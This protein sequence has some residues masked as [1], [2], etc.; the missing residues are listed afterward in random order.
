MLTRILIVDDHA[1]V[2][3][4]IIMFLDTE[5]SIQVVGEA[6]DG[7]DAIQKASLLKPDVIL[8]DLV[9]PNRDGVNTI[10]ELKSCCPSTKIII[11]TSF[12]DEKNVT[13]AIKAGADGYLLKDADGEALLRAIQMVQ[14][15]GMPLHPAVTNYL[16]KSLIQSKSA[17]NQN[18]LTGREKEILLLVAKGL[19]NQG[20]AE[21]LAISKGTV[22]VHMSNIL[23]KLNASSR[24][25]AVFSAAQRGLISPGASR[26]QP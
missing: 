15:G 19:S 7:Q 18:Q 5:P 2:R 11:L 12:D 1:V 8:L 4:G 21:T 26:E 13:A 17:E 16:L 3:K 14:T 10:A 22:K 25:E 20:V 9:M 23:S 24:T 6:K